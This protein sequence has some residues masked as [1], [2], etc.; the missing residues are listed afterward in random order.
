MHGTGKRRA[1]VHDG[2]EMLQ[3]KKRDRKKKVTPL[4][5]AA[6]AAIVRKEGRRDTDRKR[7]VGQ[8]HWHEGLKRKRVA[9]FIRQE[10]PTG[11]APEPEPAKKPAVLSAIVSKAPSAKPALKATTENADRD[12]KGLARNKRMFGMMLGTLQKFQT[13]ESRRSCTTARREE[14]EKKLEQEAEQERANVRR[15][16]TELFREL[17]DKQATER[18]LQMKIQRLDSHEQW[19]KSQAPLSCFIQTRAKPCL[20]YLPKRMTPEAEK[21]LKDTKDKYRMV[22]AEKRAKVQKDLNDI[23][24]LYHKEVQVSEGTEPLAVGASEESID[25]ASSSLEVDTDNGCDAA[26]APTPE[27]DA[28]AV[29]EQNQEEAQSTPPDAIGGKDFEPNYDE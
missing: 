8:D 5:L 25:V 23:E 10:S 28:E 7:L 13:E 1:H 9:S 3:Q 16:R 18:K 17:R 27:P 26:P 2:R 29:S 14:I 21:R 11:D 19:E 12:C 15:E 20:F 4:A 6:T 24:E 22:V